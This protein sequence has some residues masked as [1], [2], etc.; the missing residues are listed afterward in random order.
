MMTDRPAR[1]VHQAGHAVAAALASYPHHA[2]SLDTDCRCW[3]AAGGGWAAELPAQIGGLIATDWHAATTDGLDRSVRRDVLHHS[4]ADL[5][6]YRDTARRAAQRRAAGTAH[7]PAGSEL[8]IAATV[9]ADTARALAAHWAAVLVIA[10]A[11]TGR[12]TALGAGDIAA[13][14]AHPQRPGE[15]RPVAAEDLDFWPAGDRRL[16]W[17][18]TAPTAAVEAIEAVAA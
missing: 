18:A 4:R 12:V 10:R 14:L 16:H 9:W 13:L 7:P 8:G 11:L 5:H 3:H 2:V 17:H 15:A 1:A 6:R